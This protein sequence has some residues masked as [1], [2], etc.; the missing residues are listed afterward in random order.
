[1]TVIPPTRHDYGPFEFNNAGD[2][3]QGTGPYTTS[4]F[5]PPANS[6]LVVFVQWSG[7]TADNS[8][9]VLTD[10]TGLTW[11]REGQSKIDWS[12][13]EHSFM[14]VWS[15]SVG[16]S[17][18]SM[19]LTFT[20][21][22]QNCF[23]MAVY[24]YAFTNCGGVG[25]FVTQTVTANANDLTLPSAPATTSI[26]IGMTRLAESGT[27]TVAPRNGETEIRDDYFTNEYEHYQAQV[28]TG[29]T[30]T[31]FGWNYTN[32]L[33]SPYDKAMG[34]ALEVYGAT[35]TGDYAI[36]SDSDYSD[37]Q[38]TVYTFNDQALV[39][40][41]SER[42]IF[43]LI[44]ARTLTTSGS[45]S[46]ITANGTDVTAYIR[47][48]NEAH[49][50]SNGQLSAVVGFPAS[51]LSDPSADTVDW[52]VTLDTDHRRMAVG[53]VTTNKVLNLTPIDTAT[54]NS[55]DG[56]SSTTQDLDVDTQ[57]GGL[58]FGLVTASYGAGNA[59]SGGIA[60]TGLE[61]VLDLAPSTVQ[62]MGL[63]LE[64][65]PTTGT[66]DIA[67][68]LTSINSDMALPV[69][70]AVSFGPGSVSADYTGSLT[71]TVTW[72]GGGA[73]ALPVSLALTEE[74]TWA[75]TLTSQRL[76]TG[77]VTE[78]VDWAGAY[79]SARVLSG[80]IT[81]EASWV[82]SFLSARALSGALTEVAT[83]DGTF[84]RLSAA[85]LS[86]TETVTWDG[87]VTTERAR[88]G[89]IVEEATWAGTFAGAIISRTLTLTELVT[90]GGTYAKASA[91]G[92]SLSEAVDW[93]GS[94]AT[95]R[96]ASPSL[97]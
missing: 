81:E 36:L 13:S 60:W 59:A 50:A 44:L 6:K 94:V 82:G 37:V 20:H 3:F 8:V 73:K 49:D 14:D 74:A 31:T 32:R 57:E 35:I 48:F 88:T 55:L 67:A 71:E 21:T 10:S 17:P 93:A 7:E 12:G 33:G 79:A 29:S 77:A 92:A 90:W 72:V 4:S 56:S 85:G 39:G 16:G 95:A 97:T 47:A 27:T 53:T 68:T 46:S 23:Q 54:D 18:S 83:W 75:G 41:G 51:V 28:R 58:V 34:M 15:A 38:Q 2:V 19:T 52:V 76:R 42:T 86:L 80:A 30:S 63:A 69:G 11:T 26:V 40:G 87:V 45:I 78:V 24:P 22:G 9:G 89:S 70:L 96:Q 1:V 91:L 66:A 61:E 43:G 84:D 64:D 5:T 65:A 25:N 62:R